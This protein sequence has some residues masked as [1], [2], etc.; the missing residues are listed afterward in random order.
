M[1]TAVDLI[2]EEQFGHLRENASSQGW[3]LQRAFIVGMKARDGSLFSL[4]V[5]C[6]EY[7]AL[8]P[9][10]HWYNPETRML[11]QPTDTPKGGTFFHSSGRICAPWNRLAYRTVD[12]KGPHGD[13]TLA[14]WVTN[15]KTGN[16]TTVSAMA[17]RIQVELSSVQYQGR[18]G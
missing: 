8:P 14:N 10:W 13:W 18:M 4:M 5:D 11:D 9:A 12:P 3:S 1:A 17:L 16:C 2:F 15:P 7:P 6:S